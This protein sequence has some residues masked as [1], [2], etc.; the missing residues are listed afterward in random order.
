MMA[1]LSL[2]IL[3]IAQNSIKAEATLIEISIDIDITADTLRIMIKDNG[4]GMTPEQLKQV[5]D[6]FYTTRTTRKVGLGVS[7]FRQAALG[8]GGHF[9]IESESGKGTVVTAEFGYSHIDRMP[10]GEISQ[11]MHSLICCH[12]E[13]DFLYTYQINSHSFVLDTREFRKILGNIALDV[14]EVSEYIL[15]YLSEHKTEVDRMANV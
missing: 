8:T 4:Y 5:E 3:D 13:I 14:P 10:L 7:F 15:N 2:N 12:N 6:P 1:E 11:T 9:T